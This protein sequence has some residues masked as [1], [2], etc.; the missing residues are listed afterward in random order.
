MKVVFDRAVPPVGPG[1]EPVD[2]SSRQ[3]IE[4]AFGQL[5]SDPAGMMF[6]FSTCA[7][8]LLVS[9]ELCHVALPK[10]SGLGAASFGFASG[11]RKC[12]AI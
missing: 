5:G 10:G 6:E 3:G 11:L 1:C 12:V 4:P 9:N 7:Q 2:S 8:T